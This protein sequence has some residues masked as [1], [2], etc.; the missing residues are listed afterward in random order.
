MKRALLDVGIVA[1]ALAALPCGDAD[2]AGPAKVPLLER[3]PVAGGWFLEG[4]ES[5][6]LGSP[7]SDT[8]GTR[9]LFPA[10][11]WTEQQ[12]GVAASAA[13]VA[14][15]DGTTER[16]LELGRLL[17]IEW[18]LSGDGRHAAVLAQ[19]LNDEDGRATLLLFDLARPTVPPIRQSAELDTRIVA[20]RSSFALTALPS[21]MPAD[22]MEAVD[23]NDTGASDAHG[24][25]DADLVSDE[26]RVPS[27]PIAFLRATGDKLRARVAVAGEAAAIRADGGFVAFGR[28]RLTRLDASLA[29]VWEAQTG[30][31]GPVAASADGSLVVVADMTPGKR[32]RRVLAFGKDGMRRADVLVDAPLAVEI[33]VAPDGAGFLVAAAPLASPMMSK[34]DGQ[35]DLTLS[36][37][38]ADGTLLWKHTRA[39]DAASRSFA[40][41]SLSAGARTAAA[42]WVV[43]EEGHQPRVLVFGKTG[44]VVY[45]TEG[46]FDAI[47]LDPTGGALITLEASL[48]SRLSLA[49][50]AAGNAASP[51]PAR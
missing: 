10:V 43:E 34:Y 11:R 44:E 3:R 33:A 8:G 15:A 38:A 36:C 40:H 42:G 19:D 41:L 26:R 1:A 13:V 2:A 47:A 30:F 6:E 4:A 32:S 14:K 21:W 51:P 24:V 29:K 12:N 20:G 18:K 39:R 46:P 28:G 31:D 27:E 17:P 9:L 50:L 7:S 16:V 35:R 48:L 37:F 25:R 23:A 5:L 22:E 45:E 49:S